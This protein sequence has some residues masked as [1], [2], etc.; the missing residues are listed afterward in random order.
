MYGKPMISS[1]IGSATSYVN[2]HRHTGLVVPPGDPAAFREAMR[3]LWDEPLL[4]R[5]MGARAERRYR[6]LFTAEKMTAG[7]ADL[8]SALLAEKRGERGAAVPVAVQAAVS[9]AA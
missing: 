7:Y 2:E 9:A 4:A 5:E 3:R 6:E 1:E 8:Y